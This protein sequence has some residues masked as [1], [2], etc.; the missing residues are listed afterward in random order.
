M[1]HALLWLSLLALTLPTVDWPAIAETTDKSLVRVDQPP[2]QC[3][4]FVTDDI[5]DRILTALHCGLL[6]KPVY[7][8]GVQAKEVF[9]DIDHDLLVLEVAGLDKPALSLGIVEPK[10]GDQLAGDGFGYCLDDSLFSIGTV[11]SPRV[12]W[13]GETSA[14]QGVFILFANEFKP[15][16]SG[17]PVVDSTG[18]VVGLIVAANDRVGLARPLHVLKSRVGKYFSKTP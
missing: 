16:Q 10:K 6:D 17:G 8:D 7:V 15:C 9:R 5:K 3:S 12:T 18:K 1:T 13:K 14:L 2:Q 4:G 11:E